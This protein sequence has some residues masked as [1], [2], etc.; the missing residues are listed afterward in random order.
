[1]QRGKGFYNS[2]LDLFILVL[3]A[4]LAAP[5]C[6]P[7]RTPQAASFSAVSHDNLSPP[8]PPQL[9]P[10]PVDVTTPSLKS[11][12]G[13]PSLA[14]PLVSALSLR[15]DDIAQ[16]QHA[17]DDQEQ[18]FASDTLLLSSTGAAPPP[19]PAIPEGTRVGLAPPPLSLPDLASSPPAAAQSGPAPVLPTSKP[20]STTP[21]VHQLVD[22]RPAASVAGGEVCIARTVGNGDGASA[23]SSMKP[24]CLLDARLPAVLVERRPADAD[25]DVVAIKAAT[26][27]LKKAAHSRCATPL[28]DVRGRERE[29]IPTKRHLSLRVRAHA[30]RPQRSRPSPAQAVEPRSGRL[31]FPAP[32]ELLA[33]TLA[34]H[35]RAPARP[36]PPPLPT[37][38]PVPVARRPASAAARTDSCRLAPSASEASVGLIQPPS[39]VATLPAATLRA[40]SLPAAAAATINSPLS[41]KSQPD[42]LSAPAVTVHLRLPPASTLFPAPSLALRSHSPQRLASH[43]TSPASPS[44]HARVASL[45][46]SNGALLPACPVALPPRAASMSEGGLASLPQ[47]PVPRPPPA[48]SGVVLAP[49]LV[50][51]SAAS[52][53]AASSPPSLLPATP[54]CSFA[55]TSATADPAPRTPFALLPA[56]ERAACAARQALCTLRPLLAP[57]S[58]LLAYLTV[59]ADRR[60]C[61]TPRRTDSAAEAMPLLR[62]AAGAGDSARFSRQPPLLAPLP[63]STVATT[64]GS[65]PLAGSDSGSSSWGAEERGDGGGGIVGPDPTAPP[66]GSPPHHI[67]HLSD[68]DIIRIS[69][70]PGS[71]DNASNYSCT[72]G[73]GD[74]SGA[75]LT[76]GPAPSVLALPAGDSHSVAESTSTRTG[77]HVDGAPLGSGRV[78]PT[79]SVPMV[80]RETRHCSASNEPARLLFGLPGLATTAPDSALHADVPIIFGAAPGGGDG[81]NVFTTSGSVDGLSQ[82]AML[83]TLCTP[84]PP[85]PPRAPLQAVAGVPSGASSPLAGSPLTSSPTATPISSPASPLSPATPAALPAAHSLARPRSAVALPPQPAPPAALLPGPP[86]PSRRRVRVSPQI[87]L[88]PTTSLP[89]P[90]APNAFAGGEDAEEAGA[91]RTASGAPSTAAASAPLPPASPAGPAPPEPVAQPPFF[92]SPVVTPAVLTSSFQS[93]APGFLSPTPYFAASGAGVTLRLAL[94]SAPPPPA[95]QTPSLSGGATHEAVP[96]GPPAMV[97]SPPTAVPLISPCARINANVR[98]RGLSHHHHHR[99]HPAA[100]S[101]AVCTETGSATASACRTTPGAVPSQPPLLVASAATDSPPPTPPPLPPLQAAPAKVPSAPAQL[102]SRQPVDG[103]DDGSSSASDSEGDSEDEADGEDTSPAAGLPA[104]GPAATI[105]PS[106]TACSGPAPIPTTAAKAP[107]GNGEAS[108]S[109]HGNGIN[110]ISPESASPTF[111]AASAASC[112]DIPVPAAGTELWCEAHEGIPGSASGAGTAPA[113]AVLEREQAAG[114]DEGKVVRVEARAADS[115][116]AALD[117]AED[118]RSGQTLARARAIIAAIAE[119]L[120]RPAAEASEG[121]VAQTG[122]DARKEAGAE[123]ATGKIVEAGG[124]VVSEPVKEKAEEDEKKAA[125]KSSGDGHSAGLPC[126]DTIPSNTQPTLLSN[127]GGRDNPSNAMARGCS[128]PESLGSDPD[129]R[130]TPIEGMARGS[131]G[132]LGAVACTGAAGRSRRERAMELAREGTPSVSAPGR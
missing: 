52:H 53:P 56:A 40:T 81:N 24:W 2:V 60:G 116:A 71:V 55:A 44:R 131:S 46:V 83:R 41:P 87:P 54:T 43:T 61:M 15:W 84:P 129:A 80:A 30:T 118:E 125:G 76:A 94:P 12:S 119:R 91:P 122:E 101:N 8:P 38:T 73:G 1:M 75:P 132:A 33:S 20:D 77:G 11:P 10:I 48:R 23:D 35:S 26:V 31:A 47:S 86:P 36:V 14:P 115:T 22:V 107:A 97:E 6:L 59:A 69:R 113:P 114:P 120:P 130:E 29:G 72:G 45:A 67:G 112:A 13:S 21:S 85:T 18:L 32:S 103:G 123:K 66:T 42:A 108:D 93:P 111:V 82:P 105:A 65:V 126:S 106:S 34:L 74:D 25:V 58:P 37:A 57:D 16:L 95:T 124:G 49:P 4:S 128:R 51:V 17:L 78:T 102:C 28:C 3:L 63:S 89:L 19:Q 98:P 99:R 68:N 104:I 39:P 9:L 121:T 117:G 50:P 100:T 70:T 27:A 96:A 92:S 109:A 79:S 64:S 90:D 127:I 7:H 62:P 88:S 110:V 5:I